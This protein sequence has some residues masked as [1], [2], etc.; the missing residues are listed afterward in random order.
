MHNQT[1]VLVIDDDE[2][3]RR[4]LQTTLEL[5]GH[6]VITADGGRQGLELFEQKQPDIVLLDLLMPDMNGLD[7]I[8]RIRSITNFIPIIVI[9]GHGLLADSIEATRRGAC[10]YLIKPINKSELEF[11]IER[12]LE[13]ARLLWENL[14]YRERLEQMVHAQTG[15]LRES[16][17]RYRRLLESVS[18]YIYTVTVQNGKPVQTIHRPGCELITGHTL[19]EFTTD[20]GLW[21]RIVHEDDRPLVFGMAQYLLTNAHHHTLEHR[22]LHKDGS[23]RWVSNT[24]VPGWNSNDLPIPHKGTADNAVNYYDGIITDITRRKAA[25]E[26]LR[27]RADNMTVRP[28]P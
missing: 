17:A 25:D 11:S 8:A 15:E 3:L 19:E 27:S 28:R 7:V 10:D 5:G 13:R 24:L 22:I 14:M 26:P 12:C 21:F 2:P 20:P 6:H 9:S 23:V 16:R 1:S 18:N 4:Y